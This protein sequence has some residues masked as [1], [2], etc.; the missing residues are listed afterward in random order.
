M[1]RWRDEEKME[2]MQALLPA[3]SFFP[4]KNVNRSI[5]TV[6]YMAAS[7]VEVVKSARHQRT[8]QT[9]MAKPAATDRVT[10]GSK[11]SPQFS[12]FC[13]SHRRQPGQQDEILVS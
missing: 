6:D 9:L 1:N 12:R 13:P 11:L 5:E 4:R 7:V 8:Q 2:H 3:H 10:Y